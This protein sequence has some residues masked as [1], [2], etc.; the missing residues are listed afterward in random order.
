MLATGGLS[1]DDLPYAIQT[2]FPTGHEVDNNV[3]TI[4]G[5]VVIAGVNKKWS[6][7]TDEDKETKLKEL[8]ELSKNMNNNNEEIYE[9]FHL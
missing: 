5:N 2:G 1:Y 9:L 7:F 3:H 4:K 8:K 6:E